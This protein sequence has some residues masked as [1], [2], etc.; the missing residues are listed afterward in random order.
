M[1]RILVIEDSPEVRERIVTSLGFE[2]FEVV[3]AEDGEAGV[4]LARESKPDLI[5]CEFMMPKLDGHATLSALREDASTA[6]IPFIF[7]SAKSQVSDMREGLQLGADDYLIKPFSMVE[8]TNA[9]N[10]RLRRRD[11]VTAAIR[12]ALP[13]AL[14]RNAGPSRDRAARAEFDARLPEALNK[15]RADGVRVAVFMLQIIG[16]ERIRRALGGAPP[17]G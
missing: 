2:G 15:G 5:I 6:S 11:I 13:Q 10:L 8:L 9:V 14:E 1:S 17:G 16:P 12:S 4:Q 7:L 3:E